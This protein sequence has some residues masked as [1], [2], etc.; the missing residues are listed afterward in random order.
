[1]SVILNV[2]TRCGKRDTQPILAYQTPSAVLPKGWAEYD[3]QDGDGPEPEKQLVFCGDC[4]PKAKGL[5]IDLLRAFN[6]H[7][8]PNFHVGDFK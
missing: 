5:V 1:M 3:T 8:V 2:C 7:E 4:S 6:D